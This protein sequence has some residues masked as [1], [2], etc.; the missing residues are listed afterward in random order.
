MRAINLRLKDYF[1]QKYFDI[2]IFQR[3]YVWKKNEIDELYDDFSISWSLEKNINIFLG[4]IFLQKDKEWNLII[5]GQQ[6]TIFLYILFICFRDFIKKFKLNDEEKKDFF[7]SNCSFDQKKIYTEILDW[8]DNDFELIKI[9]YYNSDLIWSDNKKLFFLDGE[10]FSEMNTQFS[11]LKQK[12]EFKDIK[13]IISFAFFILNNVNVT[14]N[15]IDSNDSINDIFE[16]INSKGKKLTILDLIRNDFY[17]EN[18]E[19]LNKLD[20]ILKRAKINNNTLENIL[21]VFVTLNRSRFFQKKFVYKEL[22]EI[23]KEDKNKIYDLLEMIIFYCNFILK[24]IDE[25]N[26]F[27]KWI[28]FIGEKF[29]LKQ[30][31][32]IFFLYI[33]K[34]KNSEFDYF[35]IRK[36]LLSMIY[37]INL[38]NNRANEIEK[39]MINRNNKFINYVLNNNESGMEKFNFWF[40]NDYQNFINIDDFKKDKK[41]LYLFYFL[42]IKVKDDAKYYWNIVNN[43]FEY[44]YSKSLFEKNSFDWSEELGNIIFYNHKKNKNNNFNYKEKLIK[45]YNDPYGQ[46]CITYKGIKGDPVYIMYNYIIEEK[47]EIWNYEIVKNRTKEILDNI[48]QKFIEVFYI[49]KKNIDIELSYFD[50]ISS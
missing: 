28:F 25:N 49:D 9:K 3:K 22:K 29:N 30:F 35:F 8:F 40:K 44:V 21:N 5:D 20:D 1:K 32:K 23:F 12:L 34:N 14:L 17:K 18:N 42:N 15:E 48:K 46:Y 27:E 26:C 33:W 43:D 16:S 50:D 37:F 4:S 11:H 24:K 31:L 41:I 47:G 6:R 39:L 7:L 36:L 2:P 45:F 13:D 10:K 38:K 19:L